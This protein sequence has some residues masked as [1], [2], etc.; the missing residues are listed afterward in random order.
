MSRASP[1]VCRP[2]FFRTSNLDR[3]KAER[4]KFTLQ[5]D[6]FESFYLASIC[7]HSHSPQ[8]PL[9]MKYSMDIDEV[10]EDRDQFVESPAP[11]PLR[12]S[13]MMVT[14][15]RPRPRSSNKATP[16]AKRRRQQSIDKHLSAVVAYPSDIPVPPSSTIAALYES[17]LQE[18]PS[19][20]YTTMTSDQGYLKAAGVLSFE[21]VLLPALGIQEE[22]ALKSVQSKVQRDA[23]EYKFAMET[24]RLL[25]RQAVAKAIQAAAESRLQRC[26]RQQEIR[27][28]KAAQRLLQQEAR[29]QA[30]EKE[31]QARALEK[32]RQKEVQHKERM[33]ALSRQYPR[34][35]ELW[36]EVVY[37]T[38]S[39]TQLEKEEHMWIQAEQDLIQES[40]AAPTANPTNTA[41]EEEVVVVQAPKDPLQ[42]TTE[43]TLQ[44]IVLASARIQQSLGNVLDII[45]ESEKVR[46]EMYHKY[47]QEHQFHGYQGVRNPKAMI[48][49][50]SQED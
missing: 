34:N 11:S 18:S 10:E 14:T 5:T 25:V 48:R 38:S 36:K 7:Q 45:Q 50:L 13:N 46:K 47:R 33:R 32:Q 15:R 29:K 37:L 22:N 9:T 2:F 20:S 17:A 31:R 6:H 43:Q 23:P 39:I 3:Q 19:C 26:Q 8:P 40:A 16:E 24:C 12:T 30:L 49:F 44:D 27:N 4:K 35:Q 21:Q 1:H 41:T 42:E 28:D